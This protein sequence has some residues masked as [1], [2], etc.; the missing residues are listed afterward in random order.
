MDES[1]DPTPA[2]TK[3]AEHA[4]LA[5]VNADE[6]LRAIWK[7]HVEKYSH[8]TCFTSRYARFFLQATKDA[9]EQG[10]SMESASQHGHTFVVNELARFKA[11]ELGGRYANPRRLKE[12][13]RGIG[14]PMRTGGGRYAKDGRVLTLD[15]W[16]TLFD[17]ESYRHL[18]RDRIGSVVVRT[19]W[20]GVDQQHEVAG[21]PLIFETDFRED[22]FDGHADTLHE[23]GQR[24]Y[25]SETEALEGHRETLEHVRHLLL[26]RRLGVRRLP[27]GL[28]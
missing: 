6:Q 14:S 23:H 11:F 7:Q 5:E 24:L 20:C 3:T 28:S 27:T 25:A 2:L 10:A 16:R 26:Q 4:V 18:A 9:L 1:N 8:N 21:A 13:L 19:S 22:V 17:D 12:R 15:E